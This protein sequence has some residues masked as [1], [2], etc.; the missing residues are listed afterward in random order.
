MKRDVEY[1]DFEDKNPVGRPRL[2]SKETKRKSLVI[3]G[4]SFL[5]VLL[6]I[7]FGYG[8]LFG[9][10]NNYLLATIN[11]KEKVKE[12]ILISDIKPLIKDITL[13]EN[14]KRKV[15][16]TVLPSNATNKLIEYKSLDE[17]VA[18]VD[19]NGKVTAIS[20]GKTKIVARTKDGSS[21]TTEFNI[22]VLKDGTGV[23]KFSN[24][25]KLNNKIN[26]SIKCD[27]AKVKEIQYS[28]NSKDYNKLLTKKLND[29]VNISENDLKNS[30]I[31]FKVIYYP[32]NS[33]IT[34]Y[35]TKKISFKKTTTKK[36]DGACMLDIIQVDINS[37]KYDITCNNATV[38]K[39][40]YKIG[41]GSYVGLNSSNLADTII[42][43]ESNVTRVLYFNVEYI[44]DGTNN[45]KTVTDSGVIQKSENKE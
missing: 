20:P 10:K 33:K 9:Y 24:L 16:L 5:A 26:Y 8:T 19:N 44:I 1:L 31:I 45:K 18:I 30:E 27:N 23:C 42:F 25:E 37:A 39:I 14:T 22:T 7:V 28:I 12:N 32:N 17:T 11:K 38:S 2:A 40:A 41:N 13:K 34:K 43:E 6:L 29:T 4:L 36:I 35:K 3:A 21:K 15:Y